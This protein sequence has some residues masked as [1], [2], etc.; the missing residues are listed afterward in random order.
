M[1]SLKNGFCSFCS[2]FATFFQNAYGTVGTIRDCDTFCSMQKMSPIQDVAI[3]LRMRAARIPV[4]WTVRENEEGERLFW[5]QV[6]KF[7]EA[8]D[9]ENPLECRSMLFKALNRNRT[10][11]AALNFL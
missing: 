11:E 4:K 2:S 6:A 1:G 10:E 5:P 8:T 3:T 9:L 7:T